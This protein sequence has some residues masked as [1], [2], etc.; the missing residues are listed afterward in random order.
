MVACRR[1]LEQEMRRRFITKYGSNCVSCSFLE[2]YGGMWINVSMK[3]E[4]DISWELF[5]VQIHF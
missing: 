4:Q 2:G 1:A 3:K 5:V